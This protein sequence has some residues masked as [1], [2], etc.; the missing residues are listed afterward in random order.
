MKVEQV[1]FVSVPTRDPAQA[2]AWYRDVLG[3]RASDHDE[4][5]VETP[6]VTL[7]FWSPEADGE[8]FTA[9]T[10]GIALRVSDVAEAVEEARAGGAEVV[11]VEDTGV[12]HMGFVKDPDGNVLILHRR[13]AERDVEGS[14]RP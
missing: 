13:Y 10:A 14:E 2:A 8:A 9:N 12:C 1:D 6:N 11:G 3:L 5:E 4:C 7:S